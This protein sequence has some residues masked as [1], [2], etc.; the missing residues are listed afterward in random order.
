L[1]LCS[2]AETPRL[3]RDRLLHFLSQLPCHCPRHMA[4][5]ESASRAT[6]RHS[7]ETRAD[8][9]DKAWSKLPSVFTCKQPRATA[10]LREIGADD[11][12]TRETFGSEA[13]LC[14]RLQKGE[15][16]NRLFSLRKRGA[17]QNDVGQICG[18][19]CADGICRG[20]HSSASAITCCRICRTTAATGEGL[21]LPFDGAVQLPRT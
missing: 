19:R 7:R 3:S 20:L 16:S 17:K 18:C 5:A 14:I 6:S 15:F 21:R 9:A 4:Q 10:R 2:P 13:Y 8:P 12:P 11:G 1:Q